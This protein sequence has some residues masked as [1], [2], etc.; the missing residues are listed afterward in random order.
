MKSNQI[1]V[2]RP[3]GFDLCEKLKCA[4]SV[5]IAMAFAKKSGCANS[6]SIQAKTAMLDGEGGVKCGKGS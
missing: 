1:V 2:S 3:V 6:G 4:K 5:K